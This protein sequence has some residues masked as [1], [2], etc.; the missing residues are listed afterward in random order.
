LTTVVALAPT[1][2]DGDIGCLAYACGKGID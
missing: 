2:N 1:P